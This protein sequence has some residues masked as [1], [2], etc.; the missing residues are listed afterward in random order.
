[1]NVLSRLIN[2]LVK[3][4]RLHTFES[5]VGGVQKK[6]LGFRVAFHED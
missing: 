5:G 3:K 4:S 2:F 6:R 1:M